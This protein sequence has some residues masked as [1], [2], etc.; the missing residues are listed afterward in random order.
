[1]SYNDYLKIQKG[2]YSYSELCNGIE[3]RGSI[4]VD[5]INK[6]PAMDKI[7]SNFKSLISG[8]SEFWYCDIITIIVLV[9]Y[10]HKDCISKMIRR[11]KI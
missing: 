9:Y 10:M 4:K 1:M 3:I 5:A 6:N 8:S 11:I 7:E 2:I